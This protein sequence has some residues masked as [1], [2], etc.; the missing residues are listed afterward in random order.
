M[1]RHPIPTLSPAAEPQIRL[2]PK[3]F[4]KSRHFGAFLICCALF[5][6][7]FALTALWQNANGSFL[8]N[9][10]DIAIST[11]NDAPPLATL[12]SEPPTREEIVIPEGATPI[13]SYD[14]AHIGQGIGH[15]N[16]ETFYKPNV[17]ELLERDVTSAATQEPLVLVLHTHT[18]EGYLSHTAPYLEGDLGKIT[19][20]KNE[21]QNM[22]AIGKAFIA[23]LHKNGI[24]AIHCTVMHDASGLAGSYER[25]AQSIQFFREHYPS[26][27]YVV[28]LHR[29][30]ILTN[31]GEY[32]RAVTEIDGQNVAQ[33][34]PVIGS[35]AGGWAHDGW[36][37][38]LALALQ[39][40]QALNQNDT[41]LCRPV[42]LRNNTYNQE[43]APFAILL[44]IGTGANSIDEAVAAATLAGEAFARVILSH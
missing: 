21:E 19:Y 42:M 16:N 28:D 10:E 12:P 29:D 37:G 5:V 39:M 38:N 36:E 13:V 31:E 6:A 7:G 33:I 32:V 11:P 44:E 4:R 41:S 27:R 3:P 15:L 17:N 14:L 26:I 24:T 1:E 35:N 43:M 34:L 30:A 23:A 8:P 18:S 9:G 25:A 22:L 2:S 40:R 20:T